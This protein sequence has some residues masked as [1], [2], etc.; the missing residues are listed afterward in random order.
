MKFKKILTIILVICVSF[1]LNADQST[2]ME[3]Q[4]SLAVKQQNNG[5]Y[6]E[7][8][9]E[10]SLPLAAIQDTWNNAPKGAGIYIVD[11]D[12]RE[13]IRLKVREYMTTSVVFPFWEKIKKSIVGDES[14][15]QISQPEDNVIVIRPISYVGLDTSITMI[16]ESGHVYTFYVRT[17]GAN[18]RNT[19]DI[20]V[21]VRVPG[22]LFAKN[23]TENA[24]T[25][26]TEKTDYLDEVLLDSSKLNFKFSMSG[27]ELIAP[28]LVYS[29][30][31]RTWF[32]YGDNL[33]EKRIPTFYSAIDGYQQALNVTIDGTRLV[34]HGSG[35][36]VLKSGDRVTCVYPTKEKKKA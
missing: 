19:S 10:A 36:F 1:S 21:T 34:A 29:D 27:D 5:E 11:Y 30:G 22:P 12:P 7:M 16:G 15:Y 28:D 14:N 2:I 31:V 35:D 24:C 8:Y 9:R 13:T 3:N 20:T 17:E 33:D 26:N 6:P 18:S 25:M 32:D 23:N 4:K